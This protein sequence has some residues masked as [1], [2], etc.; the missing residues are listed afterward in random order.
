MADV[1]SMYGVQVTSGLPPYEVTELIP[2]TSLF[3]WDLLN[4]EA[5]EICWPMFSAG[6]S[7]VRVPLHLM[8]TAYKLNHLLPWHHHA[9]SDPCLF[10][11]DILKWRWQ[12]PPECQFGNRSYDPAQAHAQANAILARM[13]SLCQRS[14]WPSRC[15]DD[16]I[17]SGHLHHLLMGCI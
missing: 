7:T 8:V 4:W 14:N 9:Y 15:P 6:F 5:A 13:C 10:G 16:W 11:A 17:T 12:W 3:H 2:S 1:S